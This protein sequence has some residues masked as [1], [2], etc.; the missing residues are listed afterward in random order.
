MNLENYSF[1]F[2]YWRS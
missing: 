1:W 2:N